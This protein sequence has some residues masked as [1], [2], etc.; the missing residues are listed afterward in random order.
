[1]KLVHAAIVVASA[2]VFLLLAPLQIDANAHGTHAFHFSDHFRASYHH[3]GRYGAYGAWPFYG[4]GIVA[5]PPYASETMVNYAPP[6]VVYV[7]LPPQA[8]TCH[9][10]QQTVTVPS[11]EGGTRK[12]T[13]TRC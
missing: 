6:T 5:V 7:P 12:I 9:R 4:G 11:E 10:S 1:V 3:N 13:V 2:V 8:L